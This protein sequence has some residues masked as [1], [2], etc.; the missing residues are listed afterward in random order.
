M[1]S[2]LTKI[3]KSV[4]TSP[5]HVLKVPKAIVVGG[6]LVTLYALSTISS[7]AGEINPWKLE[8]DEDFW[9]RVER[10]PI[11]EQKINNNKTNFY[12]QVMSVLSEND[13]D[14]IATNLKVVQ[15]LS[16]DLKFSFGSKFLYGGYKD[17]ESLA[18]GLNIY[19][20]NYLRGNTTVYTELGAGFEV[21]NTKDNSKNI[22]SDDFTASLTAKVGLYNKDLIADLSVGGGFGDYHFFDVKSNL[23]IKTDL[24]ADIEA[25]FELAYKEVDKLWDQLTTKLGAGFVFKVDDYFAVQTAL[26]WKRD[27]IT[28]SGVKD[29]VNST[30]IQ[31]IP[32]GRIFQ[33]ENVKI[34]LFGGI[35]YEDIVGEND[36][37][38]GFFASIGISTK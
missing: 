14:Y 34:S 18:A 23:R 10:S 26:Y 1:M 7:Y 15:D 24:V 29:V 4:A 16:K 36:A 28:N 22:S 35:C 8:R 5:K 21:S 19:I 6:T 17:L 20:G 37:G 32:Y 3:L 11:G 2:K 12:G 27:E 30:G 25:G 38:F 9:D 31:I 33:N 13:F